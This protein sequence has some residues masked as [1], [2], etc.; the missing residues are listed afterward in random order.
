MAKRKKTDN[1]KESLFNTGAYASQINHTYDS[2][3][4]N[5]AAFPQISLKKN[6]E[7]YEVNNDTSVDASQSSLKK[8]TGDDKVSGNTGIDALQ[9]SLK[10]ADSDDK[11]RDSQYFEETQVLSTS[12]EFLRDESD[13]LPESEDFLR[14]K[15]E[16]LEEGENI[17][18]RESDKA[19]KRKRKG[20]LYPYLDPKTLK[21]GTKV[22]YPRVIGERDPDNVKHWR[23]GYCWEEKI[24]GDWKNRSIAVPIGA[25][26][27][28]IGLQNNNC[29]VDEIISFVKRSKAKG[30]KKGNNKSKN[31]KES[32]V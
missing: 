29:S 16:V 14:E 3:W 12:E 22:H 15:A 26:S 23:W 11:E 21:D 24:D 32:K 10:N 5:G 30:D 9:V 13:V 27:L 19:P 18:L 2:A 17:F 1:Q 28:V 6:T 25:V 7:I 4:D 8:I 20:S 31:S